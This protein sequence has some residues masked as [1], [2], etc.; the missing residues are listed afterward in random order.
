MTTIEEFAE[1]VATCPNQRD[2]ASMYATL[3]EH[4][5]EDAASI[6]YFWGAI[7]GEIRKRWPKGL[8]RVKAQAWMIHNDR[9]R[10]G[11][12]GLNIEVHL[13]SVRL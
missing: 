4:C 10:R 12:A 13:R 8:D 9:V 2:A 6:P 7:N 5:Q 3:M 1:F 11:I